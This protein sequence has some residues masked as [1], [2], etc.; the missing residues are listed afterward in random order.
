MKYVLI[1]GFFGLLFFAGMMMRKKQGMTL[2]DS[3]QRLDQTIGDLDRRLKDM[4]SK[5]DKVR[6]EAR[7]KLEAQVHE[8]EGK[9]KELRGRLEELGSEAKKV[10]ERARA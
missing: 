7:Q 1:A 9:Q 10:L 6:G 4:R 3:Q 8:L 2:D 5:A